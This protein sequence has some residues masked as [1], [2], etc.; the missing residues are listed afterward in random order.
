[1]RVK[2]SDEEMEE[3]KSILRRAY[4]VSAADIT[5]FKRACRPRLPNS[6]ITLTPAP[7]GKLSVRAARFTRLVMH[8]HLH[9]SGTASSS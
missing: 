3:I 8:S 6:T 4:G 7:A 9:G 1:M 2:G 5:N